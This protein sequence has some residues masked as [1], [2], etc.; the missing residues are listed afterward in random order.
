MIY[1]MKPKVH[2][3]GY[4]VEVPFPVH[5]KS[6]E[7]KDDI[8]QNFIENECSDHGFNVHYQ[9]D[10]YQKYIE[11]K[12]LNVIH[13]LFDVSEQ[14][15]EI[16]IWTY[17]QDAI[18][19][20]NYWHNHLTTST[21]NSVYYIDPPNNGGELEIHFFDNI[22]IPIKKDTLYLFPSWMEHRPLPQQDEKIRISINIEYMCRSRPVMK[23]GNV[24]W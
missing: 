8:V 19:S 23:I 15:N 22:C 24:M 5:E 20:N 1:L 6:L 16:K 7:Y 10:E 12:Y 17:I 14:L 18:R 21:V 13:S 9:N 11:E 2:L 4:F 3:N